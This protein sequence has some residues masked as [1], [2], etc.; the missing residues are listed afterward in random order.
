MNR[1]D[2]FNALNELDDSMLEKSEENINYGKKMN[3]KKWVA[4]VASLVIVASVVFG[5]IHAGVLKK[6]GAKVGTKDSTVLFYGGKESSE[7]GGNNG[8][9]SGSDGMAAV[10]TPVPGGSIGD[11]AYGMSYMSYQGPVLPLSTLEAVSGLKVERNID[12]ALSLSREQIESYA[13]KLG[14][15][16]LT[17]N[18]YVLYS[19]SFITDGYKLINDQDE[20][21]KISLLYPFIGKLCMYKAEV[22]FISVNGEK[23]A[24]ELKIGPYTGAFTGAGGELDESQLYNLSGPKNW[25]DYKRIMEEG[26]LKSALDELPE[27]NIPVIVY[28]LKDRHSAD[29]SDDIAPY[30][31]MEFHKDDMSKTKILTYEFNGSR[32]DTG[33]GEYSYGTFVPKSYQPNYGRSSYLIIIGEDIGDY[34]LR[35]YTNGGCDK[36]LASAGATVLRYESTLG[37]VIGLIYDQ[38]IEDYNESVTIVNG[39][40]TLQSE[41]PK[42]YS[43]GLIAELMQTNGWLSETLIAR[44]INGSVEMIFSDVLNMNRIMYISL[45]VT[46]PAHSEISLTAEM[47]KSASNDFF[48]DR[49][50]VEGYDVITEDF[51]SGLLIEKQ[52][53]SISGTSSFEI[54][55]Q[56]FGFDVQNGIDSVE[57]DIAKGHYM[58]E[59]SRRLN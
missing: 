43:M 39:C 20:E 18:D 14:E 47:Y 9:R 24:T 59:V 49:M 38:Y 10:P 54:I 37:D 53:A 45:D 13:N 58:L 26:Y 33:K 42:D 57:L 2:L 11:N 8:D 35:A 32:F 48:G 27:L 21:M 1:N 17:N 44:Y 12:F 6:D 46:I 4:I 31:Q 29:N 34:T 50:S 15:D 36:E 23:V 19:K 7:M 55:Q 28:E 16:G 5:L 30:I 22:P 56:D 51:T 52:T 3:W 25:E 41:I 40:K